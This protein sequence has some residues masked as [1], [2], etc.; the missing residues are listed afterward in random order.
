MR[1]IPTIADCITSVFVAGCTKSMGRPNQARA[2][3]STPAIK[4]MAKWL[5]LSTGA[6]NGEES[7]SV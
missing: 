2:E 6:R 5:F 1:T 3:P 4:E 7:S